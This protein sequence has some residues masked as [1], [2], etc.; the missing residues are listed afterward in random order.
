LLGIEALQEIHQM[1]VC[2]NSI[3]GIIPDRAKISTELTHSSIPAQ[4]S[5]RNKS[6]ARNHVMNF[7][8][9]RS[10]R[11]LMERGSRPARPSPFPR[12]HQEV[13]RASN[14]Q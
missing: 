1:G 3:T 7:H 12:T 5:E 13:A 14:I 11:L 9:A 6:S 4:V 10:E 8:S 2:L